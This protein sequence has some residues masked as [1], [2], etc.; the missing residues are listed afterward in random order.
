MKRD[1]ILSYCASNPEIIVAYIESLESQ[2]K[3]LTERL[4]AL[5]SRLNQNSRNS[6]R[7]PSTDYFVK[8]KPN[9][10]SL[11]KPSGKKPGGQEGHPGTTLDMVDHPE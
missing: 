1:E 3:E 11:R 5:E 7:P 10:K 2:V 9:P 8:E 6:S 4:V